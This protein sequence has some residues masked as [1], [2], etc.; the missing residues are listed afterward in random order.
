MLDISALKGMTQEEQLKKAAEYA[1]V[2]VG[3]LS[4][5]WKIESGQGTHPTMIGPPTKWGTAKGHFQILDNVH[6][7]LEH[8]LG[9]KL[10]RFNFTEALVGAAELMRENKARYGNDADAVRA[11]HGGW[12]KKNWGPKTEDYVQK[13]LGFAG[14]S[15]AGLGQAGV[16]PTQS[17]QP[18]KRNPAGITAE[19]WMAG[20]YDVRPADAAASQLDGNGLAA[21]R[22]FAAGTNTMPLAP[23]NT[24]AGGE[25]E[26]RASNEAHATAEQTAKNEQGYWDGTVRHAYRETMRPLFN[27]IAS[28]N[29]ETGPD[30]AYL[31]SMADNP[32]QVLTLLDNPQPDEIADLLGTTS[33]EDRA[34]ALH[35]IQERRQNSVVLGRASTAGQM[36]AMFIGGALDPTTYVMGLGAMKTFAAAGR[37]ATVLAKAGRSG[38]A[39]ASTVGENVLGNVAYEAF[40]Q[41]LGE[42]KSVADYGMAA[43]TS[44]IPAGIAAPGIWKQGL[45]AT[46]RKQIDASVNA[47][48]GY[49]ARAAKAL[50]PD[51]EPDAVRA[52]AREY[53]AA[54]IRE[55]VQGRTATPRSENTL[56]APDLDDPEVLKALEPV[57]EGKPESMDFPKLF[58]PKEDMTVWDALAA[59]PEHHT[60]MDSQLE[61]RVEHYG[62]TRSADEIRSLKP[63]VHLGKD[64]VNDALFKRILPLLKRLQEKYAPDLALHVQRNKTPG[65]NQSMSLG[66]GRHALLLDV[67]PRGVGQF[68]PTAVHEMGHAI[69]EQYIRSMPEELRA[70]MREDWQKWKAEFEAGGGQRNA[71]ERLG[72][73]RGSLQAALGAAIRGDIPSL[74]ESLRGAKTKSGKSYSDYF[75]NLDEFSAEQFLKQVEKDVSRAAN[76]PENAALKVLYDVMNMVKDLWDIAKKLGTIGPK[77]SYAEFFERIVKGQARAGGDMAPAQSM[78]TPLQAQPPAA[79]LTDV[80]RRYGLDTMDTTDARGRA[81]QKAI[82]Q[83]IYDSE[84]W[85]IKNPQDLEKMKTIMKNSLFDMRTPGLILASSQNPVFKAVAGILVENTM[86]GSGRQVTAALRKAQWEREFIGNSIVA[87]GA[88][89]ESF[90]NSRLGR[91]KGMLDDLGEANTRKEF[92]DLVYRE[93]NARDL[94]QQIESP[95]QVKAAAD[96]LEVSFER[97]LKAQKDMRTVGWGALPANSRGYIPRVTDKRKWLTLS[98]TRKQALHAALAQQ[99]RELGDMDESFAN[100]VA[101]KYL[102]HISTNA[103]GGHE[104]PA[105]IHDPMAL[106][107]VQEAMRAA[108]M[109]KVEIDTFASKLARG[110][111]THTKARLSMDV[112]KEYTDTDGSTFRLMDIM[113]TDPIELLR[114]QARRVSGEVALTQH[115]V[116]GSAGAK[117]LRQAAE[118]AGKAG[119]PDHVK[120]MEAFDQVIAEMLGRPFGD[121]MPTWMEGALTANAASN[122]GMMGWM[123]MGELINTATGLGV[124]DTLKM[125]A[126]FPRIMQEVKVLAKG[127]KVEN[128]ILGSLEVSGAEFGMAGYKMVTQYDNPMSQYAAVGRQDSGMLIRGIRLAGHKLGTVSLHRIIQATQVRGVAEQITKKALRYINEGIESKALADM[129]FTP[130]M[131]E[132][133]KA[134]LPNIAKF[135]NGKL[136][137]LDMTKA[138]DAGLASEFIAIINRGAGQLIQDSFIGEKGKWQHSN[139]GKMMTQFR[140][141]PITAM[142]KQWGRMRGLHGVPGALGIV[143]AAAPMA[144]AL[145]AARTALSA[146]GRPD[147]D[148]YIEKQFQPI[149]VGRGLMNY[150]GALG[151]APDMMDALSAVLIPKDVQKEYGLTN[152][153]GGASTVGSVVPI[154]GY[155]DTLLKGIG[156]VPKIVWGSDNVNP[157]ALARAL[158][159]SNAP[160]FAQALNLLR[161]DND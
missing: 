122:L 88:H 126:D 107:Y 143:M 121:Q 94:G 154:V 77:D 2:P 17:A 79:H 31:R 66:P 158:P 142:E 160:G 74:Y 100:K 147:A 93:I 71:Q 12:N 73:S 38:A 130:E 92:N 9:Q 64:V 13:V 67:D 138:K 81:T 134:E 14:R 84:N 146:V 129:G 132:R 128:G 48:A 68:A 113:E 152:R 86:G 85:L 43:A 109:T 22:R 80:V 15:D 75:S 136:A 108:G 27:A 54:T 63:G 153:A 99:M 124:L 155:G 83:L 52:L 24:V 41:A 98:P 78:Q 7:N 150:I 149:A 69:F 135:E 161:P 140:A 6:A 131:R 46:V 97:M 10:D 51:A 145:Y 45:E 28:M 37:G 49:L 50:G 30:A 104:V 91:V 137:S 116:M 39:L 11:Y 4:G 47:Q 114:S 106:D 151:L 42:H 19:Q 125:L 23:A 70:R 57:S 117:L 26:R 141:F 95:P 32:A 21:V 157:H 82:A 144:F 115:G 56:S 112:L 33:A 29:Q 53:E 103:N 65:A 72:I 55:D 25:A 105:N 133:I 89:Y 102:D 8:R 5:I 34:L 120:A 62:L 90:R 127:G 139:L 156:E 61:A 111:P 101:S 96:A 3:V 118:K 36:S 18:S 123:Q 58:E 60:R 159:F 20:T 110:G 87:Y 148:D 76:T 35:N 44:L 1:N 119:D 16:K 40:Q 59:G